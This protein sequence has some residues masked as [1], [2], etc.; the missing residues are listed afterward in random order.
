MYTYSGGDI[1]ET[2]RNSPPD[3]TWRQVYDWGNTRFVTSEGLQRQWRRAGGVPG[4]DGEGRE[5]PGKSLVFY[6]PTLDEVAARALGLRFKVMRDFQD[7]LEIPISIGFPLGS[8]L[9]GP[10]DHHLLKI[11]QSGAADR[12]MFKWAKESEPED[13]SDRIFVQE[14]MVLGYRNLFFPV[15]L[16]GGGV[17]V[18]IVVTVCEKIRGGRHTTCSK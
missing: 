8:E 11:L 18:G 3:S 4:S 16:L 5:V 9:R 7:S 1:S 10:L 12:L 14:A 17:L 15:I 13:Y 6:G 2:L